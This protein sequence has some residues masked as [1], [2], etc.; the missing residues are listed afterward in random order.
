MGIRTNAN[1]IMRPGGMDG[2]TAVQKIELGACCDG[3]VI[4]SKWGVG[5]MKQTCAHQKVGKWSDAVGSINK[6]TW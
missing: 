3:D 5:P 6:R 4:H 1:T 2:G